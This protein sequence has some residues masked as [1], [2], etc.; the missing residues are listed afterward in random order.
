MVNIGTILVLLGLAVIRTV[1]AES[2]LSVRRERFP[3]GFMRLSL[4]YRAEIPFFSDSSQF[5]RG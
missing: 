5:P 3:C 1:F 4:Y 2:G